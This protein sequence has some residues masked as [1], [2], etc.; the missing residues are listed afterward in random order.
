MEDVRMLEI[1]REIARVITSI[2]L[3]VSEKEYDNM[4]R[5][6][7]DKMNGSYCEMELWLSS[8]TDY[9]FLN[10]S[11]TET[12]KF[13]ERS[14]RNYLNENRETHSG[15]DIDK[16]YY[17]INDSFYMWLE[18]WY[19]AYIKRLAQAKVQEMLDL[20]EIVTPLEQQITEPQH[21]ELKDLLPE[22][23]KTDEAVKVF[24]KAIDA[25]L[26]TYSQEGLKWNDTKQLLA[27]FATKVS[28]K[29]SLTIRLDKDGNKT[30]AWNPF[31]ALFNEQ[32][33]KGAKQNW[34]RLN[35]R[36]EPTGFEKVDALF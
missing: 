32:G 14:A 1:Y 29:F 34:M 17:N 6:S 31:E 35:T 33:L 7:I 12:I 2:N 21:V 16:G 20:Q 25:K 22:K 9:D 19:T 4:I 11:E 30:T 26:I 18:N 27:Y 5:A 13:F 15:M 24:Q 8:K 28:E 10:I 23:L 36:F 3:C